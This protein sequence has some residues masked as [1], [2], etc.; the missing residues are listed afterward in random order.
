MKKTIT[1]IEV[2]I[3]IILVVVV[4]KGYNYWNNLEKVPEV[5]LIST[6]T[7]PIAISEASPTSTVKPVATERESEDTLPKWDLI[8][9][10]IMAEEQAK[11]EEERYGNQIVITSVVTGLVLVDYSSVFASVLPPSFFMDPSEEDEEIDIEVK[12]KT[13]FTIIG[14]AYA[15]EVVVEEKEKIK[16]SD[17]LSIK[18]KKT[19]E[20]DIVK[21]TEIKTAIE[22]LAVPEG[23]EEIQENVLA[24]YNKLIEGIKMGIEKVEARDSDGIIASGSVVDEGTKYMEKVMQALKKKGYKPSE[25]FNRVVEEFYTG[26]QK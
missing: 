11:T 20:K 9:V 4:V 24:C 6:V 14:T 7:T 23:Y 19:A 17:E 1:F 26:M 25:N 2:F 21:L 12:E 15:E 22:E 18:F 16:I 5:T 13:G 8:A 10:M 3:V